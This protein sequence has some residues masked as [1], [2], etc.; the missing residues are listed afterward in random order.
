MRAIARIAAIA[1]VAAALPGFRARACTRAVL[2][3]REPMEGIR[4]QS[5]FRQLPDRGGQVRAGALILGFTVLMALGSGAPASA[6]RAAAPA[7]FDGKY[8]GTATPIAQHVDEF[9]YIFD[10][11]MTIAAP[12]VTI[13]TFY[14]RRPFYTYL[15]TVDP[16]GRVSASAQ[17]Q[18]RNYNDKHLELVYLSLSRKITNGS[19]S[20]KIIE[21]RGAVSCSGDVTMTKKQSS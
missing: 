7:V 16:S 9:L 3:D 5:L 12:R 21:A 1:V 13:H 17:I 14:A 15:G 2:P 6:Q 8:I 19:F 10:L 18:V 20:G 4:A 11:I